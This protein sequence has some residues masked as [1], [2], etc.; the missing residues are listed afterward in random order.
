M[1][2]RE[3][4]FYQPYVSDEEALSDSDGESTGS[5][6]TFDPAARGLDDPRYAIIRTTGP[7]FNTINEQ[8]MYQRGRNLGSTYTPEV[9]D[10]SNISPLYIDPKKTIQTT[11]F[12]FKSS[13]RDKTVYPTSSDFSLMLPRPYK[14]VTQIQLVQVSYQYFL[15]T[16]TDPSGFIS[17]IVDYLS[18]I[19]YDPSQCLCCFPTASIQNSIGV[20]E[21]GRVNPVYPSE[22]LTHVITA[23][24]G[25]YDDNLLGQEMDYQMNKTPPFNI[26]SFT[27]HRNIF[28]SK[29]SLYHLFNEPGRYFH[30]KDTAEFL[31]SPS[32]DDIHNHYIPITYVHS[33]TQPSEQEVFV[34]YYYPVLKEIMMS[35][36]DHAF[37]DLLMYDFETVYSRVVL[38]FEGLDSTFYYDLCKANL[39]YLIKMRDTHTFK[40]NLI[41]QYD[42]RY[43][44]GAKRFEV[45]HTKLHPSIV[46][47]ISLRHKEH[48]QTALHTHGLT[49][50]QHISLL[51]QAERT[52]AVFTDLTKQMNN[53][54]TEVGIPFSLYNPEYL[55]LLGNTLFTQNPSSV[56]PNY[57]SETETVLH[58]IA[59][60]ALVPSTFTGVYSHTPTYNFGWVTLM[61]LK[62][63]TVNYQTT[64]YD[65]DT[66]YIAQLMNVNAKSVISGPIGGSYIPG[67][68]GTTVTAT[69]FQSLYSTFVGYYSLY[70]SQISTINSVATKHTSLTSNFVYSK[71]YNVLPSSLLSNNAYLTT[72]GTGTVRYFAD[73]LLVKGSSPFFGDC[74]TDNPCCDYIEQQLLNWYGCLPAEYVITTL[75]YKLGLNLTFSTIIAYLSTISGPTT[76]VPFNVYL[77]LNIDKSMNN[78][79]V[80]KDEDFS[81]TQD[82][83]SQPKVVLGKLLTEGSGLTDITQTIIQNPAQFPTPIGKLD[84]LHFTMYLDN[85]APL[86]KIVPFDVSFTDWDAV[87]QID[88]EIGVLNRDTQL[89]TVPTVQW[90]NDKR[91]F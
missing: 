51:Q 43:N 69:D 13:N 9:Q 27:E 3:P 16:I 17:T 75:P 46:K 91:P 54:L 84:R 18:T 60:Q 88:E 74:P 55:T 72:T 6:D 66:N 29:K 24:S 77:Q 86:S 83:V 25:R 14:N 70:T 23:R 34:A 89:S 64:P 87:I 85:M 53:A 1:A 37:L 67:Y 79:D 57:L 62:S 47:D 10:A 32:K 49:V 65:Y 8:L 19:G 28:K 44:Q 26:V 90:A 73:K 82:P 5:D 80:A 63:D 31:H 68:S 12:S 39:P 59:T 71:Y 20:E 7:A 35:Q 56:N 78:M 61:D 15:N 40:Y 38:H 52:K 76:Q 2:G 41:H 48:F 33:H 42:W 45:N 4:K 30:K 58:D 36:I 22:P 11:L 50:S 21:V 81:V